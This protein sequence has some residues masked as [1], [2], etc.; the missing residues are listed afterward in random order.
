MGL[1][2]EMGMS[3]WKNICLYG[4]AVNLLQ[5]DTNVLLMCGYREK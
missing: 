1:R 3:K 5:S 4:K 2:F